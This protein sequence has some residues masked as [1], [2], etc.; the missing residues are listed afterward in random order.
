MGV[1]LAIISL[2][3]HVITLPVPLQFAPTNWHCYCNLHLYHGGCCTLYFGGSAEWIYANNPDHFLRRSKIEKKILFQT[4]PWY[5]YFLFFLFCFY[6]NGIMILAWCYL[7]CWKNG[8]W[9]PFSYGQEY[10]LTLLPA[11][12]FV[13]LLFLIILYSLFWLSYIMLSIL[14]YWPF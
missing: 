3:Y 2:C 12:Y 10:F 14:L 1:L 11:S 9:V 8:T 6:L 4:I 7:M 13:N 5:H